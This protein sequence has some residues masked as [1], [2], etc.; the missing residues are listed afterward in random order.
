MKVFVYRNLRKN[1]YSVKALEGPNKGRVIAH[2]DALTLTDARFKVSRSGRARVLREKQK[3]V[4]AGCIGN[5]EPEQGMDWDGFE[6][7][8]A[9]TYNPYRF[10]SF[11]EKCTHDPVYSSSKVWLG[12]TGVFALVEE[13]Q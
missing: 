10:E 6:R 5:W 3:N 8:H 12:L 1:C 13:Q 9:L 2:W 4:H 7:A 11:V